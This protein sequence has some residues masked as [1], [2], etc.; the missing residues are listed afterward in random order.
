MAYEPSPN[1][2]NLVYP[3]DLPN[4]ESPPN[5]ENLLVLLG[6]GSGPRKTSDF[7]LGGLRGRNITLASSLISSS[8]NFESLDTDNCLCTLS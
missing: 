1:C 3:S 2:S 5:A 7:G 4:G 8:S 6:A